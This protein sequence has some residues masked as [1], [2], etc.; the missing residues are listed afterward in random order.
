MLKKFI[1]L[2][3]AGI[4][5]LG[6]LSTVVVSAASGETSVYF[7]DF[8]ESGD[9]DELDNR[10]IAV[11]SHDATGG[12]E[13][14]GAAKY[15]FNE[16]S[17]TQARLFNLPAQKPTWEK[18]KKYTIS[19]RAKA[20]KAVELWVAVNFTGSNVR[21]T[22]GK[23]Y[24]YVE[25][26]KTISTSWNQ[27]SL[28]F[29][30]SEFVSDSELQSYA[31][32]I[33]VE[34]YNTTKGETLWIDDAVITAKTE[35][36]AP[37]V[38]YV[39][40]TGA[41]QVGY[42]LV[43]DAYITDLNEEDE[44]YAEY[45]WQY[46]EGSEWK[47]ITNAT[48]K[49]YIVEEE[50]IGKQLRVKVTPRSNNQPDTGKPEESLPTE[51][52]ISFAYP[53]SA[54]I[55]GI[56][57]DY[58]VGN[59]LIVDWSYIPSQ[60]NVAKGDCDIIWETSDSENGTFDPVQTSVSDEYTIKIS[61]S[62]KWLRVRIIPKDETGLPGDEVYSQPQLV[63]ESETIEIFV[64]AEGDDN[65]AGTVDQPF[66]TIEKARDAIRGI[67][68]ASRPEGGIVVN[69]M[70]G[71]Y[72]V[73]DTIVFDENDSGT[74]EKPIIYKAYNGEKVSFI[75]GQ[76][77]DSSKIKKVEEADLLNRLIDENAKDHL[78]M[79]DL[80]AQGVKMNN[81]EAYGWYNTKYKPMRIYMNNTALS[82]ARW[83]NDDDSEY[84]IKAAPLLEGIDLETWNGD[85]Q[86]IKMIYPD[87]EN[88]TNKWDIKYGDAY[89]GGA[90]AHFWSSSNLRIDNID[91]KNKI[92]TTIDKAPFSIAD[93]S[94]GGLQHKIF[95]SN[96]FEEIDPPGESYVDRETISFIFI[97]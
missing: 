51:A 24:S 59:K 10:S 34:A 45:E 63:D 73:S 32:S 88:R 96:I 35:A 14:S 47:P 21:L 74:K 26:R 29:E 1:A 18:N 3:L 64:S 48:K 65:N 58:K 53:P 13:G 84:A 31:A 66:K 82:D 11:V 20:S 86:R 15:V 97:L 38:E 2:F 19:F 78:Y 62:G 41:A 56:S 4:M 46:L 9:K 27:Y 70:G 5:I 22:D 12:Y 52:V 71:T 80:G 91:A 36:K 25:T 72:P 67:P 30:I 55:N 57:G 75:G 50:Y 44:V 23:T 33:L 92:V 76:T 8:N 83:P 7:N 16:T 61:D 79:L 95:F 43:A 39:K 69:I 81:L 28:Q 60:S 90:I 42:E 68:E 94:W 85:D 40:I 77:L 6:M 54:V 87:A 89:L 49:T 93:D 37:V 17:A